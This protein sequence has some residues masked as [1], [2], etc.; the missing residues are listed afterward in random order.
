MI[1]NKGQRGLWRHR[2]LKRPGEVPLAIGKVRLADRR[3]VS[4]FVCESHAVA[5]AEEITA[6]DGWRRYMVR[7]LAI[8][9]AK[10]APEP[11]VE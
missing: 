7:T 6:L 2:V 3:K 4:G 10:G 8:R 11:Q 5:G 1:H 9:A